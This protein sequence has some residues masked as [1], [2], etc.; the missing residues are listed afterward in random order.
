MVAHQ[1]PRGSGQSEERGDRHLGRRDG[2]ATGAAASCAAGSASAP[3]SACSEG[4]EGSTDSAAGRAPSA[5]GESLM[6]EG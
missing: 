6:A 2:V 1:A 4:L 3:D 5:A